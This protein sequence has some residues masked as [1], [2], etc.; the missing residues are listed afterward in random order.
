MKL[1]MHSEKGENK[2]IQVSR[3]IKRFVSIKDFFLL[4]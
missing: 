1:K 2:N 4:F 3:D